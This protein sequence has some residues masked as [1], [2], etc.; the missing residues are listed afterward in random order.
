MLS[1]IADGVA[2]LV[3]RL[4]PRPRLPRSS[5][6]LKLNV[7]S[8][9]GVAPGWIHIDGNIHVLMAGAP[10]AVLS[11]LHRRAANVR[12]WLPRDEYVRRLRSHTFM[13]YDLARG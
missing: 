4:R 11:A 6:P 8:G 12:Q 10:R 9:L 7:G 13:H 2:R 3:G 1:T 5:Q